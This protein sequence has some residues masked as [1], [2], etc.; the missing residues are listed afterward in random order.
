M[1]GKGGRLK[2]V[3]MFMRQMHVLIST[4]SPLIEALSALERQ[5]TE[6]GWKSMVTALKEDVEQGLALSRRWRSIRNT[7][8]RCAVDSFPRANRVGIW[9]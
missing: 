9:M 2:N 7:S 4:G 1:F 8:M 5:A 3:A 6:P